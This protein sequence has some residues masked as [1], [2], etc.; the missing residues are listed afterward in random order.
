MM[1]FL[2]PPSL[3]SGKRFRS[4]HHMAAVQLLEILIIFEGRRKIEEIQGPGQVFQGIMEISRRFCI[5]TYHQV[6]ELA[7]SR[8]TENSGYNKGGGGTLQVFKLDMLG[9]GH[10]E[11]VRQLKKAG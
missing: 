3:Q 1:I 7:G 2:F 9:S 10:G 8:E 11:P 4:Q 5:F 6:V